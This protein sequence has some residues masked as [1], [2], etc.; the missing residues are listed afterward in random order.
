MDA[1]L[2]LHLRSILMLNPF[3]GFIS[4]GVC[5]YRTRHFFS[6]FV[7][8]DE[9]DHFTQYRIDQYDQFAKYINHL[10]D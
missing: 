8:N 3:N 6:E 10:R 2:S 9:Q 7:L 4:K 5:T 1:S